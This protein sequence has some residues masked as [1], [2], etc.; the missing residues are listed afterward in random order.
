[1]NEN[2]SILAGTGFLLTFVLFNEDKSGFSD[3]DFAVELAIVPGR[4]SSQF[5][6]K[7]LWVGDAWVGPWSALAGEVGED[8]FVGDG[9]FVDSGWS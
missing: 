5:E 8:V 7:R 9:L 1:M 6:R 2:R 4:H 3:N